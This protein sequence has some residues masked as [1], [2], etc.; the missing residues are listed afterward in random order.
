MTW[1]D[2]EVVDDFGPGFDERSTPS[3]ERGMVLPLA[4]IVD[5]KQWR[6]PLGWLIVV[7]SC[8]YQIRSEVGRTPACTTQRATAPRASSFENK[9]VWAVPSLRIFDATPV[10]F[11]RRSAVLH[12]T[13]HV[14]ST[15]APLR[16]H[17]AIG[18]ILMTHDYATVPTM[19][20]RTTKKETREGK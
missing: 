11:L 17:T 16:R 13:P 2:H 9:G 10:A 12:V 18:P 5:F 14:P 19:N 8:S 3:C 7:Y 6:I 15:A 1:D 20:A 4:K